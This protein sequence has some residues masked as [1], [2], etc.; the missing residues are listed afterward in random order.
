MTHRA[1]AIDA[2][3]PEIVAALRRVGCFVTSL[4]GVGN[5]CP[6]IVAIK[7]RR[8]WLIEVKDGRKPPSARKLTP[9][10]Q[11]WHAKANGQAHVVCSV[12]EALRLVGAIA[13]PGCAD[14]HAGSLEHSERCECRC[15]LRNRE[16]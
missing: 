5:G 11:E 1:R 8:V 16:E 13:D 7:G 3:Q 15:H 12:D 9:A 4:A 2:N 10:E 14:C 6:D